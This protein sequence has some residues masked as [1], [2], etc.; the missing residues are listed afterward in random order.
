MEYRKNNYGNTS[1][2]TKWIFQ[3]L[4]E[5][6]HQSPQLSNRRKYTLSCSG[7]FRK[8]KGGKTNKHKI[9]TLEDYVFYVS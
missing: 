8:V 3:W 9:T 5:L 6:P 7:Q 4:L 2:Q 1:F